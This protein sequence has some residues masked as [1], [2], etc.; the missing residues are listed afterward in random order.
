MRKATAEREGSP[1]NFPFFLHGETEQADS[2]TQK[3]SYLPRQIIAFETRTH[4]FQIDVR[5]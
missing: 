4:R 3:S 1:E 5:S 2:N